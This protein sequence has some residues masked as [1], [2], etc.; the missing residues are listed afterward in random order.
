MIGIQLAGKNDRISATV[1]G[2]A[3][4]SFLDLL[5]DVDS[6]VSHQRRGTV[7][8]EIA[9]LKKESPALIEVVGVSRLK[10]MDYSQAIQESLIE[11][12][13]Q[14]KQRP[15]QPQ[16]Y[17]YS[18][19]VQTQRMAGQAAYLEWMA[20]IAGSRRTFVDANLKQ[21][22]EYLTASGS[23]SLG[24][25][26]GSLDA[27]MVHRGHEFRVWSPKWKRPIV[28][29]FDKAILADVTAHLKQ[30][31]EVIG[32]L[33]RNREGEPTL[34]NVEQFMPL[35]PVTTSPRI[36]DMRG[37]LSDIYGGKTLGAYLDELR[38]G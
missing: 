2:R 6:M 3:F 14:L 17:S 29:H 32:E 22:V 12:L 19:L 9:T 27:I 18:G 4:T 30:E 21:H 7:R 5:K 26:R 15:E 38:N 11:G 37:L 23:K 1:F 36:E 34:M 31:V 8:W 10:E 13:E 28:C 24:S 33:Q 20:V 16:F 35:E 25:V